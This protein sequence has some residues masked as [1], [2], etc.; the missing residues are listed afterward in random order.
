MPKVKKTIQPILLKIESDTMKKEW[1]L[2]ELVNIK[3]RV[4]MNGSRNISV[5]EMKKFICYVEN[6]K[7][8]LDDQEY[9]RNRPRL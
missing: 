3:E 5:D 4:V 8:E 2:D 7:R 1:T 9:M 6:L